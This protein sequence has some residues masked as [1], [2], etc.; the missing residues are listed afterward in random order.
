MRKY[1]VMGNPI[2]HS[3]SPQ[4]HSAFAQQFNIELSYERIVVAQDELANALRIFQ[5]RGG[6]GVNITLPL[7]EE[8]YR[9]VQEHT[10]RADLAK[11]VNTII[12]DSK[13]SEKWQ[14][15]NTDGVGL[16]RDL[17]NNHQVVMKNKRI[18]IIGAGGATKGILP[19]L[20]AEQPACIVIANRTL[21][22]AENLIANFIDQ[23]NLVSSPFSDL[24]GQAF[25][26]VINATSASTKG[27]HFVLPASIAK[28][29]VCYDLAYGRGARPFLNWAQQQGAKMCLDGL[30][31][32]VEQAAEAFYVW[33]G[34]RPETK[35]VINMLLHAEHNNVEI[36]GL[37][38]KDSNQ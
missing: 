3:K 37:T 6:C 23:R 21:E 10:A 13:G 36:S 9:L 18:V 2:S 1:A 28:G 24:A 4:I 26:L 12:L 14:G 20:L 32:L 16:L 27:E 33:H 30:G 11:A 19:T 25:D 35:P 7:K 31:M 15:D 5:S 22:K 8:A 34:K 29:S 17:S 38:N